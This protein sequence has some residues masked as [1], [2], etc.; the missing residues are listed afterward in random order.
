MA[1]FGALENERIIG[2]Y[3]AL[4]LVGMVLMFFWAHFKSQLR[5]LDHDA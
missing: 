5:D 2:L 3:G 1:A 4:W